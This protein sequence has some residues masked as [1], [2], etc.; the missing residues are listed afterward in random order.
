[1]TK[2]M[3][4]ENGVTFKDLEKNIFRAVCE[5][6]QN[7]TRTV[8]ES[9]DKHLM[10]TRDKKAYRS[11][12]RRQ[13]TVKT[14]FGEVTYNRNV[15][16]V[17]DEDGLKKCVYLMDELLAIKNVGLISQNMA[18]QMVS[19][20][21]ELSFRECA[22]KVSQMTGQTISA[23]GVWNVVQSL[24]EQV[25][26]EEKALVEA[27][28]A[29]QIHGEEEAPVLFEEADG[30]YVSLQGPARKT[31]KNIEIKVGIAYAGWKSIGKNRHELEGKVVV[32]GIARTKEFQDCREAAIAEKYN[33]D[34]TEVRVLNGDGASWIKKVHDKETIFQL[35][36]F[37][38][39]KAIM[40]YVPYPSVRADIH[41]YLDEKNIPEL[42]N[43]LE[44]YRD[45]V[46]D[47]DDFQKAEKLLKYFTSNKKGLLPYQ[48]QG[49]ELPK[50]PEGV[51]YKN[52]GTMENHIWSIIAKR[53]KRGHRCW[54]IKGC[55]HISKILAKRC[56]GRLS[57]VTSKLK[58]G[59]F[60]KDILEE[61][62][63]TILT[64]NKS[65]CRV[66][67]GYAY[68]KMGHYVALD[69]ALR[70]D[71]NKLLGVAGF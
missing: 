14:V 48:E 25:C 56:S 60:A 34:E 30:V 4:N 64:A 15:Y 8:L 53:V 29:G 43:Y 27:H 65:K 28:K 17:V 19:G 52:L 66:G 33:L 36:P 6:A 13:T 54:S 67:K 21:T 39:N 45:S 31:R 37:H 71:F 62:D 26:E 9:Y 10:E 47:E 24:G 57:D 23:M 70:G 16:E 7:Y 22:K 12:G 2:N 3:L 1:M 68:P 18:E 41:K 35:D 50:Q 11:K 59:L 58:Y 40:D 63:E 51:L 55:N 38:R 32:A 5:V 49:I 20:I 69:Q 46:V 61:I 44:A 42:L